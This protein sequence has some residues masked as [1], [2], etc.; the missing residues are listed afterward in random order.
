MLDFSHIPSQY[1]N[2]DIQVFCGY[3][4]NVSESLQTWV[5]PRG[6]SMC[7]IFAVG[8]G[9]RGGTGVI[10]ANSTAAGGGGGGSGGQVTL[11]MPLHLL[12]NVLYVCAPLSG[13]SVATY[14]LLHPDTAVPAAIRLV[15]VNYGA[16]GGNASGATAGTAGVAATSVNG[17]NMP[18]GYGWIQTSLAGQVGTAGG[19]TVDGSNLLLPTSGLVIT[20]GTGG[21]GL[22]AA[23][24]LATKGGRISASGSNILPTT[25]YPDGGRT[26]TTPPGPPESGSNALPG[27]LFYYG[28]RGGG[29]THGSATGAGLVQSSGGD[30][31]PGCGGGGTGGALTGSSAGTVG[32]G[33][34]GLV[35][36]TCW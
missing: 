28:G 32:K 27:G 34:P 36:I 1:P 8:A 20:G 21:G 12:P 29:S 7:H 17:G 22:G 6:K 35:I 10:G 23:A 30:G 19:T 3:G 4:N 2:A 31:A 9:G 26:A 15:Q 14:V 11:K 24:G 18:L 16:P 25:T 5:K 33:G 13:N